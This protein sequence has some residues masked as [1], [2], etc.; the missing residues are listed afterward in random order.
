MKRSILIFI[1]LLSI[2]FACTSD[3]DEELINIEGN[4]I[5][6]FERDGTSSNVSLSFM[7][8]VYSGQSQ[9]PKFPAICSGNY[10]NSSNSIEFLNLC[11]WTADFDWTLILKQNWSYTY[12]GEVLIMV[13]D[14][15]DKYTLTKQ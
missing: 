7:D 12:D 15:G 5:G 2:A 8:G 13:K 1:G 10:T 3:Y 9:L 14:N 6:T 11:F 4:Y